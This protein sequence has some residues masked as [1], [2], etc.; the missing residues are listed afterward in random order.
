[1]DFYFFIF[2]CICTALL[3]FLRDSRRGR[4]LEDGVG[5]KTCVLLRK[6][7]PA[8]LFELGFAHLEHETM[9]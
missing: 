3:H 9:R 4:I 2:T 1:M 6:C 8:F 5:M 7:P